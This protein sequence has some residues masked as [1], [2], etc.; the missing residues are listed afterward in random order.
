MALTGIGKLIK[1]YVISNLTTTNKTIPG[2]INELDSTLD[3]VGVVYSNTASAVIADQDITKRTQGASVTLPAGT[4][5]I[6]G[7]WHFQTGDTTGARNM[8]IAIENPSSN[9]VAVQRIYA[10]GANSAHLQA[11]YAGKT[12]AGTYKVKAACSGPISSACTSYIFA[13]RIK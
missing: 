11:V 9:T 10:H 7:R 2:A 5:I 6:V 8:E 1:D 4:F 3:N 12:S 13:V